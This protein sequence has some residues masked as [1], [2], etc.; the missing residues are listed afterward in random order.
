MFQ[1]HSCQTPSYVITSKMEAILFFIPS[2]VDPAFDTSPIRHPLSE[3]YVSAVAAS[4]ITADDLDSPISLSSGY[5]SDDDGDEQAA[6][7]R[8]GDCWLPSTV[9]E[10]SPMS[11][12]KMKPRHNLE[13][14][15]HSERSNRRR[16]HERPHQQ[17]RTTSRSASH[18][19]ALIDCLD[20]FRMLGADDT[21]TVTDE[22]H[23]LPPLQVDPRLTDCIDDDA[24]L[25]CR[26]LDSETAIGAM[27]SPQNPLNKVQFKNNI[28]RDQFQSAESSS[29]SPVEDIRPFNLDSWLKSAM[30]DSGNSDSNGAARSASKDDEIEKVKQLREVVGSRLL[31]DLL[32]G[33]ATYRNMTSSTIR[34]DTHSD[35]TYNQT[36]MNSNTMHQSDNG[37]MNN[38]A[39]LFADTE[40]RNNGSVLNRTF[41]RAHVCVSPADGGAIATN[42]SSTCADI[43]H[44]PVAAKRARYDDVI[45]CCEQDENIGRKL[46]KPSTGSSEESRDIAP[47][48]E[49]PS[50]PTNTVTSSQVHREYR[51]Q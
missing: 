5:C 8:G 40:I 10:Q 38:G 39:T 47:A 2:A 21:F 31:I 45:T 42:T 11:A 13:R 15:R 43:T 17:H 50:A 33:Q 12:P 16:R 26:V 7:R 36:T 41:E 1:D 51:V 14:G 19:V 49:T 46:P 29:A 32:L 20:P 6:V 3:H 48:A 28:E 22:D 18:E 44:G 27:Y 25:D 4:V 9:V 23:R 24:P 37:M 35:R 34:H 30:G